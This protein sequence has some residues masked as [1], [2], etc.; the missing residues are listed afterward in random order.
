MQITEPVK[1]K[2]DNMAIEVGNEKITIHFLDGEVLELRAKGQN[3]HA[4][5]KDVVSIVMSKDGAES[6]TLQVVG[7]SQNLSFHLAGT[8]PDIVH[9]IDIPTIIGVES[10]PLYSLLM[11]RYINEIRTSQMMSVADLS[12]LLGVSS[13]IVSYW[14]NAQRKPSIK[15]KQALAKAFDMNYYQFMIGFYH[16]A[17]TTFSEQRE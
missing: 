17:A 2:I 3:I 10:S 1:L 4:D 13:S 12:K 5:W 15:N 16:Y 7:E 8:A 11:G 14:E 6:H 9:S